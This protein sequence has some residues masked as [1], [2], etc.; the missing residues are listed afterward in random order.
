M[1]ALSGVIHGTWRALGQLSCGGCVVLP[2]GGHM[3][4][5]VDVWSFSMVDV[6][7][8]HGG[9]VV[10]LYGGCVV[11]LCVVLPCDGCMILFH[12]AYVVLLHGGRM[13]VPHS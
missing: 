1:R 6:I 10:L 8:P 7:L 11:L 3:S 12:G 9:R 13:V 4:S 2:H 5:L